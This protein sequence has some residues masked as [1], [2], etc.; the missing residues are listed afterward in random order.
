MAVNTRT[1][2]TAGTIS[3]NV[4]LHDR[5][6]ATRTPDAAPPTPA[7]SAIGPLNGWGQVPLTAAQ[8]M[9]DPSG[10]HDPSL[11]SRKYMNPGTGVR[12]TAAQASVF[13]SDD[14]PAF[15]QQAIANLNA[16][17]AM[18]RAQQ[19]EL[20]NRIL[21]GVNSG[22]NN[23]YLWSEAL[24][25]ASVTPGAHVSFGSAIQNPDIGAGYKT[26]ADAYAGKTN[27]QTQSLRMANVS[28]KSISELE[29]QRAR[30][31]ATI[32]GGYTGSPQQALD[33]QLN[34]AYAS[35]SPDSATQ[36]LGR[37]A[38]RSSGWSPTPPVF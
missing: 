8:L 16:E 32:M 33:Q 38:N 15:L 20:V 27:Q 19:S 37:S 12:D 1:G 21:S 4:D 2:W 30:L 9:T 28:L 31:G 17:Q 22:G 10:V 18:K 14:A 29:K 3:H 34:D 26:A 6:L 13:Q 11:A 24:R 7:S 35:A 5:A 25:G 36:R 23:A